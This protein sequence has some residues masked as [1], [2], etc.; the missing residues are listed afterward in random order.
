MTHGIYATAAFW[1][2]AAERA[3]KT[4]AQALLGVLMGGATGILDV[5]W[6]AGLS[7]AALATLVSL[8]T[9]ISQPDFTAGAPAFEA[10]PDGY[11]PRHRV[12]TT[13]KES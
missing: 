2:G 13:T 4:F 1:K 11:E 7:V 6:L 12:A 8:L 9:S 10:Q 5:D 3:V